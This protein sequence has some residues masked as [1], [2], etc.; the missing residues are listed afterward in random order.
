MAKKKKP[1]AFSA[2]KAVK[3]IAREK[4]GAPP[5]TRRKESA[6]KSPQPKHKKTL[7]KLLSDE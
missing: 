5:V 6:K 3:S 4:M 2:V 7:S 1:K